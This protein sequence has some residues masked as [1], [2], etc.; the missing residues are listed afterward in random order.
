MHA[1][2][3]DAKGIIVLTST[4]E[5]EEGLLRTLVTKEKGYQLKYYGREGADCNDPLN[6]RMS[7][8]FK[9]DEHPVAI[10][11]TDDNKEQSIRSIRSA[12]FFG[13]DGLILVDYKEANGK[14]Q[15]H[16]CI[17]FCKH[18]QST[19]IDM[20]CQ[21]RTCQ[22]CA[23]KC[24]HKYVVDFGHGGKAGQLD[25]SMFC[26]KCGQRKPSGRPSSTMASEVTPF[27][28]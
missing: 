16:V 18:C 10:T 5:T 28:K 14:L 26:V 9:L 24:N 22:A 7:L 13:G 23:T 8:R 11:A 3:D 20:R 17:A 2:T 15:V 27:C 1:Q 19:L 6:E 21:W 12:I 4:T 25:T